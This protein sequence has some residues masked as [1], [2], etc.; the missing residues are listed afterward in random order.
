MPAGI[1]NTYFQLAS[2]IRCMKNAMTRK[3]LVQETAIMNVLLTTGSTLLSQ[4]SKKVRN[5][6]VVSTHKAMNT[7]MYLPLPPWS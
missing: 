2:Q 1:V 5:D 3:A 7:A 4:K 6:A